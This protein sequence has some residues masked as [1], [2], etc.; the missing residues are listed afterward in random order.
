MHESVLVAAEKL[1]ALISR[2]TGQDTPLHP[3]SGFRCHN[4][5]D[6]MIKRGYPASPHS[7]HLIGRAIDIRQA[8]GVSIERMAEIANSISEI[9]Q[10]GLGVY[11]W[12]IHI[13]TRGYRA[14]W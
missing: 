14:R 3:N 4:H 11:D 6:G 9:A 12:G 8:K 2:E 10:G 13:D 5:N 7:Q 1:R